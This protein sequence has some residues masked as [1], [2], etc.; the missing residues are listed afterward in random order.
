M[1]VLPLAEALLRRIGS[2]GVSGGSALL[3]H[4]TLVAGMLGGAYAARETRLLALSPLTALLQG[5]WVETARCIAYGVGAA[6]SLA[7]SWGAWQ[8]IQTERE[9]SKLLAYGI[10][11]WW[12]QC[13]MPL[14]FALIAARLIWTSSPRWSAR[15]S[16]AVLAAIGCALAWWPPVAPAS[17]TTPLLL[18]LLVATLLGAPVFVTIGG[19][20]AILFWGAE[21]PIAS[22]SLTH[23]SLV[24]NPTL[25]ALPLFTLAGYW[26]AEG[27]ASARLVRVFRALLGSLR[28][29]PALL[30]AC[31]C[32]FFTSFTG[33][34]GVTILALG[35]LLMPVLLG[36][37]MPPRPALGLLTAS[38][39][40]GL[41]FPP[42]LPV[43]LYAVVA[44]QNSAAGG[45]TM[46]KLFLGGAL[47]GL[48]LL[49]LTAWWGARYAPLDQHRAR[50]DWHE[51]W[52]AS[53][54]AKWELLLPVVTLTAL[55]GGFATAV[56]AAALTALYAFVVETLVYRDL[57]ITR[58]TPRVMGEC[59]LVVGGVLLILG[60]ALGFTN[61]LVDAQVAIKTVDWA[62]ATIE[63]KYVFFLALNLA[64]LVVGC[65]MDIY[66]AI[67][68]VVPLLVPLGEAYGIDPV[69]LGIVFLLNL[70][71]GYL[72]P[73][74]GMNLF[75]SSYRFDKPMPEVARA[76]FPLLVVMA[77]GVLALT[78]MPFLTTGIV[79]LFYD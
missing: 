23:Y 29:G 8:F 60:V 16:T 74:V 49:L 4:L 21:T 42:C 54:E 66:S 71:L 75:L 30:T 3:Q 68:V 35:G 76:T 11:V 31:V 40:L 45:L 59:G 63:S 50:V 41:L 38:G 77:L 43:L 46:Q 64:L 72:T 5:G 26:L 24:T 62:T 15:A 58:D 13:V 56:E 61:Y 70:E 12:V 67:V 7:L 1:M 65:L 36:S 33:A 28:G 2:T 48:V 78:Y 17:M 79:S 10:P 22:I 51:V 25:P 6:V 53:R 18:V 20:A 69:H 47:P 52:S 34:S 9:A 32:A 57:S 14:G 19:A 39:S 44:N 27:G 37:G 73:P 55:F